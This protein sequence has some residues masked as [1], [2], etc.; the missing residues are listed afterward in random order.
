MT[1]PSTTLSYFDF[2]ASRGLE[3]RLALT[4]AGVEFEDHRVPRE[5]WA[6][7]KPN[8]PLGALPVLTLSAGAHHL[9][10]STAI[11]TYVGRTCC[12]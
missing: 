8:T 5:G 9:A 2:D 6:T 1:Q 12:A 4:V 11:L 10:H 7:L 3:C